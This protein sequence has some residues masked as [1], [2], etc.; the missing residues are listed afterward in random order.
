MAHHVLF[1][2]F[3]SGNLHTKDS[4]VV[5]RYPYDAWIEYSSCSS[6]GTYL[7]N[8]FDIARE[9][10]MLWKDYKY[11]LLNMRTGQIVYGT[12]DESAL[13]DKAIEYAEK[14]IDSYRSL[15]AT[16][17]ISPIKRVVVDII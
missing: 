1:I 15:A 7:G 8:I 14:G 6:T 4:T 10:L 16:H 17:T 5:V 3:L 13:A 2:W 9:N 12:N 11:L